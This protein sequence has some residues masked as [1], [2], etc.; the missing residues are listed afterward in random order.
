MTIAQ[1][2]ATV[3]KSVAAGVPVATSIPGLAALVVDP[4]PGDLAPGKRTLTIGSHLSAVNADGAVDSAG[5]QSMKR[6]QQVAN[7]L[8]NPEQS[9]LT[10]QLKLAT[11][12]T[13]YSVPAGAISGIGG[14]GCVATPS[15]QIPATIVA[16]TLG[17]TLVTFTG[18]N[19]PG[20]AVVDPERPPSCT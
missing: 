5:L 6:E 18:G 8:A 3:G 20:E 17:R 15:G 4:M 10:G 1:C 9:Q 16:S 12:I 19:A 13:V 7:A 14:R 2:P 11:P